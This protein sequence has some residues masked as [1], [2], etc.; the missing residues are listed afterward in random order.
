MKKSEGPTPIKVARGSSRE[1]KSLEDLLMSHRTRIR[2]IGAG[3]AGNNTLSRLMEVGIKGTEAIAVNTDAQDLLYTRA[4]KKI[5]IG[6][7]T[8]EGLGAGS[9]PKVGEAAAKET[10]SEIKAALAGSDM[11]FLTCGLGGGTGTGA[12]PVIAEIAKKSGALTIAVVTLPF[13]VE[14]MMRWENARN[15]LERL[16]KVADTVI[17]IPNDKLLEL[18]PELPLNAAFKVADEILVNA[19]K[20][21]AELV[22]EEGLVN[23]DFADIKAIMKDGGTAMIGL[24]ESDTE[25]R[26]IDSVEK[27]LLNPLLDVDINGAKGALI[28]ITGGADMSLKD[29]RIVMETISEKLDPAARVI[30]GAR[31]DKELQNLMRVMLIVTGLRPQAQIIP[32]GMP[33]SIGEK[34]TAM[35][36]EYGIDFV[37]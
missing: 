15:G 22:T 8:T 17:L 16:R 28:N 7:E 6:K 13:T 30:W 23:L 1:D 34:R 36:E 2:V 26:A 11:V 5:L 27:A 37:V 20:G 32:G 21:I 3:G 4:D 24:G 12:I 31:I 33:I 10:E 29:A 18:V 35:E 14:G 9:D 25:N 19:V